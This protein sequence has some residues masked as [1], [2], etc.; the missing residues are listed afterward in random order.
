MFFQGLLYTI[1]CDIRN[2]KHC[3]CYYKKDCGGRSCNYDVGCTWCDPGNKG[4]EL[5]DGQC[6]TL[7]VINDVDVRPFAK[8]LKL[9]LL[10]YEI[11]AEQGGGEPDSLMVAESMSINLPDSLKKEVR[12]G[13]MH[14]VAVYAGKKPCTNLPCKEGHLILP[15]EKEFL[16]GKN[17]YIDSLPKEILKVA[18]IVRE[19]VTEELMT[20]GKHNIYE[21]KMSKI[22]QVAPNYSGFGRCQF[23]HPHSHDFPYTDGVDCVVQEVGAYVKDVLNS[24][25]WTQKE[26]SICELDSFVIA[27]NPFSEGEQVQI[28]IYIPD[29]KVAQKDMMIKDLQGNTLLYRPL[30]EGLNNFTIN[31]ADLNYNQVSICSI[32]I[33]GEIV[34][35]KHLIMSRN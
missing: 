7:R 20:F 23:P 25:Q 35:Y 31:A 9:F 5:F 34:A 21:K 2:P 18:K 8:S 17:G 13:G 12:R 11:A 28:K 32:V 29:C 6:A 14:I 3:N 19:A 1:K 22:Y 15:S 10:A 27:R 4:G 26:P 16:A 24:I 33:G 30:E